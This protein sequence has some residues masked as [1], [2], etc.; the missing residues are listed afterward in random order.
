MEGKSRIVS[1][2]GA[3]HTTPH[4]YMPVQ[5]QLRRRGLKPG[6]IMTITMDQV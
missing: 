1:D 2:T 4:T 6:T 3:Q 5:E